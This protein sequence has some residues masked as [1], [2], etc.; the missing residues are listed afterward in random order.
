MSFEQVF[1]DEF[2][3]DGLLFFRGHFLIQKAMVSGAVLDAGNVVGGGTDG[4]RHVVESLDRNVTRDDIC[5]Q[6]GIVGRFEVHVEAPHFG[7]VLFR[8]RGLLVLVVDV[9]FESPGALQD[10]VDG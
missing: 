4:R 2:A 8:R 6:D 1:L 3:I 9:L 10:Q 7:R 5:A